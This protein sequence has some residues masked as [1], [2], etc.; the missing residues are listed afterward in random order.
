MYQDIRYEFL[1]LSCGYR[2]HQHERFAG[3][4]GTPWR[5]DKCG[6]ELHLLSPD[7]V[8]KE[9]RI[10]DFINRSHSKVFK[11]NRLLTCLENVKEAGVEG[12][13]LRKF[14]TTALADEARW[15][16]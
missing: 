8:V 12:D 5:C 1:C 6:G 14:L 2:Q 16:E 3:N 4:N 13:Y 7:T 10:E 11:K 9:R 15:R